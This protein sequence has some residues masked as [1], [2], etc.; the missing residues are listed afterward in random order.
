M[1]L[2]L[3]FRILSGEPYRKA[4]PTQ[5]R[6]YS[7]AFAFIPIWMVLFVDVGRSYLDKANGVGIWFYVMG[8]LLTAGLCLVVWVRFVPTA[9]SWV[10]A[11]IVWIITL[12]LALT[13]RLI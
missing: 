1:L 10:F 3:L 8:C 9:V 13:N 11:A 4:T 2:H 5:L 6:W 7:A 12:F